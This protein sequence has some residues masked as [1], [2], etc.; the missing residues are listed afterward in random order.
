ML[1]E[2]P[3]TYN[4][5]TI[6]LR[7]A[8]SSGAQSVI[9]IGS[10][11]GIYLDSDTQLEPVVRIALVLFSLDKAEEY[12]SYWTVLNWGVKDIPST[13]SFDRIIQSAKL[14]DV[15]EYVGSPSDLSAHFVANTRTLDLYYPQLQSVVTPSDAQLGATIDYW[16]FYTPL[17][18]GSIYPD[19]RET[20]LIPWQ[21]LPLLRRVRNCL[22][23]SDNYLLNPMWVCFVK[24]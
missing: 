23:Q 7:A 3:V 6:N 8:G 24:P 12:V 13:P 18:F 2:H 22:E 4:L 16:A 1:H 19:N 20:P 21:G 14:G 17:V 15:L 10:S 9:F 5:R 11:G